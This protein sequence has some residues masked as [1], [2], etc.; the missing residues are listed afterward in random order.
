[1]AAVTSHLTSLPSRT[2]QEWDLV[3]KSTSWDVDEVRECIKDDFKY[4]ADNEILTASQEKDWEK[5]VWHCRDRGEAYGGAFGL[6]LVKSLSLGYGE[7]YSG[8]SSFSKVRLSLL[9]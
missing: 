1:M 8:T 7:Q 5:L 6:C 9:F 4:L 2:D 3:S